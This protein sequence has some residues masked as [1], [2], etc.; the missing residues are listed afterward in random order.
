MLER[1]PVRQDIITVDHND[2]DNLLEVVGTLEPPPLKMPLVIAGP[3]THEA[4]W[5]AAKDDA[6]LA[7]EKYFSAAMKKRNWTPWDDLPLD[8]VA[9]R[10]DLLSEDTVTITEAYFRR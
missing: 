8:E 5:N 6:K 3:W 7:T 2:G 10:G 1:Q 9:E 4:R